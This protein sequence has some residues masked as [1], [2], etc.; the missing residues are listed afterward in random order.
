MNKKII[1]I[2][3]LL[4]FMGEAWGAQGS[5]VGPVEIE[6]IYVGGAGDV[7]EI[8][9]NESSVETFPCEQS[10]YAPFENFVFISGG[11][12]RPD[13]M[14]AVLLAAKSQGLDIMVQMNCLEKFGM[15]PFLVPRIDAVRAVK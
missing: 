11:G 13:R 12:A 1:F 9:I 7:V 6:S 10:V 8:G 5:W 3:F 15:D 14:L 4:G 2:F